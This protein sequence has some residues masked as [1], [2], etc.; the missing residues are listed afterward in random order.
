MRP[1]TL[2]L[3][4]RRDARHLTMSSSV[5][6]PAGERPCTRR[7]G[8]KRRRLASLGGRASRLRRTVR[9]GQPGK[10]GRRLRPWRHSQP[11][12]DARRLTT[13]A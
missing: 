13:E 5:S 6:E 3:C 12:N 9:A 4:R 7:A 8:A 11:G 2:S 1:R 10:G